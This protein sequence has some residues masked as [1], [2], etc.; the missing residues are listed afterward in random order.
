MKEDR[1]K[2][3]DRKKVEI[4]RGKTKNEE[5]EQGEIEKS[6]VKKES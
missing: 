5:T 3:R 4:E 6:R 2:M 1:L